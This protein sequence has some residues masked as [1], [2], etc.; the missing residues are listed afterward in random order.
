MTGKSLESIAALLMDKLLVV[1]AGAG[2]AGAAGAVQV[3]TL[4][5]LKFWVSAFNQYPFNCLNS[6]L[7][8]VFSSF[9]E[10]PQCL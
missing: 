4:V 10:F 1:A 6:P 2:V 9:S 3:I 8:T 5:P 7:I